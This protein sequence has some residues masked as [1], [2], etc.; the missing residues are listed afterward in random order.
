MPTTATIRQ[1]RGAFPKVKRL[2]ETHGSVI[3]SDRGQ[4]KYLLSLYSPPSPKGA[5][6]K[7][8]LARLHRY[9]PRPLSKAEAESLHEENRGDR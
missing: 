3:V 9:Q 2:V 6:A 7:D 4:P 8:Y 1:L 5:P